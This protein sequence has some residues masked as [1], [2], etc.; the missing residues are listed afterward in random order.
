MILFN[1]RVT[2]SSDIV[3]ILKALGWT[4]V[5]A[6]GGC[7]TGIPEDG[8]VGRYKSTFIDDVHVAFVD[9][10]Y[11]PSDMTVDECVERIIKQ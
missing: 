7:A 2:S 9:W 8:D 10:I 5:K 6:G 3:R 4:N 1:K 11:I